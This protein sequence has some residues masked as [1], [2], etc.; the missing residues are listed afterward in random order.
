MKK[1]PILLIAGILLCMAACGGG[2]KSQEKLAVADTISDDTVKEIVTIGAPGLI[3]DSTYM[4][5]IT[6][7]ATM[8][9]LMLYRPSEMNDT[10]TFA[11]SDSVDKINFH[12]LIAGSPCQVVFT[13]KIDDEPIATYIETPKTYANAI[14]RWSC[15]NPDS[16]G[17]KTGFELKPM[18]KVVLNKMLKYNIVSWSLFNDE[19]GELTFTIDNDGETEEIKA[20]IMDGAKTL[21]IEHDNKVYTKE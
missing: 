10:V 21:T 12:G 2:N 19:V 7:V 16:P 13:G 17:Q 9:K 3:N 1:I 15:D 18:G 4:G 14:G 5:I 8:N 6:E 11:V 20:T